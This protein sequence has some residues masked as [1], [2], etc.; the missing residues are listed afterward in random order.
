M[1]KILKS[2]F[3]TYPALNPWYEKSFSN[4]VKNGYCETL[5]GRK[6]WFPE[7]DLTNSNKYRNI[8]RNTPIQGGALDIIKLALVYVDKAIKG[9]DARIVHTIHDEILIEVATRQANE[10]KDIVYQEMIRA[11]NYFLKEVPVEVDIKIGSFWK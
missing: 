1:R 4:L 5:S 10:I 2:Y 8:S 3:D 6:R 11:G 9:Y 7:L